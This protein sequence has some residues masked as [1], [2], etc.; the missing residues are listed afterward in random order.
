MHHAS[1]CTCAV[2]SLRQGSV[3]GE[4]AY[5]TQS[6]FSYYLHTP[7]AKSSLPL[8]PACGV[9]TP[10]LSANKMCAPSYKPPKS[11]IL[12]EEAKRAALCRTS[13]RL[14]RHRGWQVLHV[15]CR[16]SAY[17]LRADEVPSSRALCEVGST[18][19]MHSDCYCLIFT[20]QAA[21]HAATAS[22]PLCHG[23][24]MARGR[25]WALGKQESEES[26]L[27]SSR[28][29]AR[30]GLEQL[31]VSSNS[32][33]TSP[34]PDANQISDG[35]IGPGSCTYRQMHSRIAILACLLQQMWLDPGP[36][37]TPLQLEV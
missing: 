6:S 7:I 5:G 27:T 32:R 10:S 14:R 28:H 4:T 3:L 37:S 23:I 33:A 16:T 36:F 19:S 21:G 22:S 34:E 24:R 31:C 29:P 1:C 8:G 13:I 2:L 30:F 18:L 11:S 26:C 17:A 25:R 20:S 35:A 9:P 12:I 15:P